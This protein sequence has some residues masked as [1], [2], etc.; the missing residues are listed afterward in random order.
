M[1]PIQ[2]DNISEFM[3]HAISEYEEPQNASQEA[4][5]L[6]K[7]MLDPNLE[8]RISVEDALQTKKIKQKVQNLSTTNIESNTRSN[9]ESN[10]KSNQNFD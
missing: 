7:S 1:I 3:S 2:N 10:N 9:I 8:T 4:L 6:L 5:Y